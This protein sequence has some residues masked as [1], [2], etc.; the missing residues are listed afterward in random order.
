MSE[1]VEYRFE[2]VFKAPRELVWR[3]WTDPELLQRWYGPGVDTIIHRFDLQPGGE[4][5]NEMRWG[6]KS[7]LSKMVFQEVT[8]PERLVWLHSSADKDWNVAPSQMMPDWPKTL[9]TTVSFDDEGGQT[10]VV[11]TQVP[12]DASDAESACFAKMMAGMDNGWGSGYKIIDEI[13][14]ELQ[15]S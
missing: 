5:R 13:L 1:Q 10:R 12:V 4:W 7:D 11:L 6:E 8:A 2:R 15:G 9:L 14:A 3:T